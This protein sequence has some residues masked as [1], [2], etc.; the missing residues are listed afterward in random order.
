MDIG[1][2]WVEVDSSSKIIGSSSSFGLGQQPSSLT[3]GTGHATASAITRAQSQ[4]IGS[5]PSVQQS[6]GLDLNPPVQPIVNEP[7]ASSSST[8]VSP[9]QQLDLVTTTSAASRGQR[10]IYIPRQPMS[11]TGGSNN[12]GQESIASNTENA[13]EQSSSQKRGFSC[14]LLC[15]LVH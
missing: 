10:I 3:L 11:Q 2:V 7:I 5:T 6:A 12:A 1:Q 9:A 13:E 4:I 14:K 15:V 8:A